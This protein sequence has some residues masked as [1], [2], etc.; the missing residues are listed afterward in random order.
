M[1][2]HWPIRLNCSRL[3]PASSGCR[4]ELRAA[5][6]GGR[7][8]SVQAVIMVS[9]HVC[10]VGQLP[11]RV[12]RTG[13]LCSGSACVDASGSRSGGCWCLHQLPGT[14]RDGQATHACATCRPQDSVTQKAS[15]EVSSPPLEHLCSPGVPQGVL[16]A[17]RL[18]APSRT[19]RQQRSRQ[20]QVR[21]VAVVHLNRCT[22]ARPES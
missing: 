15:L 18:S 19:G 5:P 1:H 2:E 22:E 21:T 17:P 12:V 3:S 14:F 10:G 6:P 16:G 8:A 4:A 9:A 11:N 7:R 20:L 13:L